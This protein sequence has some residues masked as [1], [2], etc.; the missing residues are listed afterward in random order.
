MSINNRRPSGLRPYGIRQVRI[1]TPAFNIIKNDQQT[2]FQVD[3]SVGN[4]TGTMTVRA[5]DWVRGAAVG[6]TKTAGGANTITIAAAAGDTINGAANITIATDGDVVKLRAAGAG[7]TDW[8][9]D[10]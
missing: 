7:G 1:Q 10:T 8:T 2:N 3:A 4:V 6:F 9:I 5:S